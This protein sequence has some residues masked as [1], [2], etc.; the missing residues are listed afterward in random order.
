MEKAGEI[1]PAC[2]CRPAQ[3]TG[4][5]DEQD[6]GTSATCLGGRNNA[7]STAAKDH[8]I[9]ISVHFYITRLTELVVA[10]QIFA[11]SLGEVSWV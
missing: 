6:L 2:G 10:P 4:L 3:H 1:D 8:Y 9:V 7:G 5:F 11:L